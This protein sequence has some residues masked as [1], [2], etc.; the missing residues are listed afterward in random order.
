MINNYT[1]TSL[2]ERRTDSVALKNIFVFLR[3]AHVMRFFVCKQVSL[4]WYDYY[5]VGFGVRASFIHNFFAKK[6]KIFSK[7]GFYTKL[8]RGVTLI[9]GDSPSQVC[10]TRIQSFLFGEGEKNRSS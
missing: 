3:L 2:S 6:L 1:C 8:G 7:K 9:Q 4:K 5:C 10:L